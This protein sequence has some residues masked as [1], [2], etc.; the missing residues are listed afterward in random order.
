MYF[1]YDS[2]SLYN[3]F[4]LKDGL[5]KKITEYSVEIFQTKSKRSCYE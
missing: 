5:Y 1:L 3:E 4:T 2:S